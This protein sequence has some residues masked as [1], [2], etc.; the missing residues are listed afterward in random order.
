MNGD[1]IFVYVL[2]RSILAQACNYQA[3]SHKSHVDQEA[4]QP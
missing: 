3:Y 4:L 2:L 1:E